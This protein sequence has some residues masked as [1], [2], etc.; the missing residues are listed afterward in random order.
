MDIEMSIGNQAET[1]DK[2]F[3]IIYEGD[4]A[5]FVVNFGSYDEILPENDTRDPGGL[6]E[7]LQDAADTMLEEFSGKGGT[8]F[9][10]EL[11][12]QLAGVIEI[13]KSSLNGPVYAKRT[14][15][16]GSILYEM[17]LGK[18]FV[19]WSIPIRLELDFTAEGRIAI[20]MYCEDPESTAEVGT[21]FGVTLEVELRAGVGCSIVSIG[22][23]GSASLDVVFEMFESFGAV[24]LEIGWD[25]GVYAKMD[26]GFFQY[27][28]RFSLIS[29][30]GGSTSMD[31]HYVMYD[32]RDKGSSGSEGGGGGV[33]ALKRNKSETLYFSTLE[34]AVTYELMNMDTSFAPL[35][36]T[37]TYD[38]YDGAK[39]QIVSYNGK[40][41]K[42]YIDNAYLSNAIK[43]FSSITYDNYNYLKLVYSVYD[44][45]QWST[46]HVITTD[47]NN[48]IDFAVTSDVNGI[49]IIYARAKEVLNDQNCSEFTELLDVY[50]VTYNG[51]FSYPTL[52]G[53]ADAYKTNLRIASIGGKVYAAWTENSEYN[54]I[55]MS[56]D[57]STDS[58]GNVT[59]NFLTDKNSVVFAVKGS[60]GWTTKSVSGLGLIADIAI[61][62]GVIY[63]VLD[64]D[65]DVATPYDRTLHVIDVSL[66]T[67][68]ITELAFTLDS[69]ASLKDDTAAN[70][71]TDTF[72][73]AGIT[74][75]VYENGQLYIQGVRALYIAETSG[76]YVKATML[77][78]GI[79][80]DFD[81]IY[82]K[83]GNLLGVI[84]TEDVS[85]F[86]SDLYVKLYI[87]GEFTNGVCIV[88]NGDYS[89]VDY[90]ETCVIDG[91][92]VIIYKNMMTE[93]STDGEGNITEHVTYVINSENLYDEDFDLILS[94]VT[95][96]TDK[97][98]TGTPF[99]ITLTVKNDSL[100]IIDEILAEILV[101][102][103]VIKSMTFT[104]I[105]VLPGQIK[106]L[107]FTISLSDEEIAEGYTVRVTA[108]GSFVDSNADNNSESGVRL[109]YP[110]LTVNAK[111]V[112]VGD[113]KYM[114]VIVQ[115]TGTLP[116]SGYT[117]YVA[118]GILDA[119][120]TVDNAL[121]ELYCTTDS[122]ARGLG[123]SLLPAGSFKYYTVEL[124]KVYFTDNYVTLA[125][126]AEDGS[127]VEY[128][129]DN[130]Y[131]SFSMEENEPV[132]FGTIY[133]LN[134]YVGNELVYSTEY[135][136][137]ATI[138]TSIPDQFEI[139]DGYTFSGWS[140]ERESMPAHDLNVYGYFIANRY[141]VH[142]FV[143]GKEVYTDSVIYGTDI[144]ERNHT[145]AEG[146][147]FDGWYLTD[148]W[149]EGSE[150]FDFGK[151]GSSDVYLYGKQNV[152]T[153]KITYY[154]DSVSY[155]T[156]TYK[157]GDTII[158][159]NYTAPTGYDFSGWKLPDGVTT[160]PAYNVNLYAVNQIRFYTLT[161]MVSTNGGEYESV[162]EIKVNFGGTIPYYDYQEPA[163]Y[164]FGGWY[165]AAEGG[166]LIQSSDNKYRRSE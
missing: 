67:P 27:T 116:M 23:Y 82:D 144:P 78:P 86:S 69:D 35:E 14:H 22:I 38:Q 16:Q 165:D 130:N 68:V 157:Y 56:N 24:D 147:T 81:F 47:I 80:T 20:T 19:V 129:T 74:G 138:D 53:G 93:L 132:D 99:D 54:V 48:E 124:N 75:I 145:S 98:A 28:Q 89:R 146:H 85:D 109:A 94:G 123:E 100:K 166:Q 152:N 33:W 112:V 127:I 142:Y 61:G 36:N 139:M 6:Y 70:T 162:R 163:G 118:N 95:V 90:F 133:T 30:F 136:A 113:I 10:H 87:N 72:G 91:I 154:V 158:L 156:E 65:C 55:G 155:K 96:S 83:D 128:N 17:S 114:L 25:A 131:M 71:Y 150:K 149:T 59:G 102:D 160:M 108:V 13:E 117:V 4:K 141:D 45:G 125:V 8:D 39:P 60:D 58:E 7:Q 148:E 77:V 29:A 46:P 164:I 121:Y 51:T 42:F 120:E 115:N 12:I 18:T 159:P 57:Y 135:R 40:L 41:Y 79:S 21:T 62:D 76:I 49:H 5:Y 151:M 104:D 111:Y 2:I 137:G 73:A 103:S 107:K 26:L 101:G 153:Y 3:S 88:D 32:N 43:P 15:I 52:I 31:L 105:S 9:E 119:K 34:A 64:E 106:D 37:D 63:A 11:M 134:Y 122:E 97:I 92:P 110:D 84:Y 161:Y 126:V 66:D 140:G 44:G 50:S 1:D 143:D